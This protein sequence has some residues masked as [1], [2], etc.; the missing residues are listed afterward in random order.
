MVSLDG[1]L[2]GEPESSGVRK[3]IYALLER[4]MK[5]VVLDLKKVTM[6]NS[7]GLGTIIAVLSSVKGKGGELRIANV[8]KHVGGLLVLTKLVKVIKVYETVGRALDNY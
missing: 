4:G 2:L 3:E 8:G 7:S 5:K 1:Q 6:M